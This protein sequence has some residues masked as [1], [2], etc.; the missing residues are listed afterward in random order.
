M[1]P[2]FHGTSIANHDLNIIDG[3]DVTIDFLGNVEMNKIMGS[4]TVH[5]DDDSP[6][7]YVTN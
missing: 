7:F 1:N 3:M 5:K 2:T 4:T 6:I